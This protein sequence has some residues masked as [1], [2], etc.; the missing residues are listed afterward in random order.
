MNTLA[1]KQTVKTSVQ[2]KTV[3][4]KTNQALWTKAEE[5]RFGVLPLL[6]LVVTCL[7]SIAMA[8]GTGYET[9]QM[10]MVTLP[11]MVTLSLILAVAPMRMVAW[12]SAIA[13]LMDL[14]VL[15]I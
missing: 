2:E 10:L 15:A 8:F 3:S 9:L 12:A 1:Q 6:L 13:I 11:A 4:T 7:G 5:A 14:I